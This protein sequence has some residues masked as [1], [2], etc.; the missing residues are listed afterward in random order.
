MPECVMLIAW[1]K[2]ATG[3]RRDFSWP[4]LSFWHTP[5]NTHPPTI[6]APHQFSTQSSQ[7]QN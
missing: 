7:Y 1:A 2:T 5:T 4:L 3:K 6:K